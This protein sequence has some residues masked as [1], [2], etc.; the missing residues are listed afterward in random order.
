AAS[1]S[2]TSEPESA[3]VTKKT[4]TRATATA[5]VI[6]DQGRNSKNSKSAIEASMAAARDR[7]P[8][9]MFMSM[10]I[11]VFPK[12]VIHRKV[13]NVGTSKTPIMNSRTV[14]PRE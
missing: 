2:I 7:L 6:D 8:S 11:A 9:A 14:R 1:V 10:K 13:K 4:A 12:T 5:E 3:D